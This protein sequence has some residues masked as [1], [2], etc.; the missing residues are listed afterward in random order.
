MVMDTPVLST[1]AP[2]AGTLGATPAI[3]MSR[4]AWGS[5]F[6]GALAAAA[7]GA[8]LLTFGLGI[9]L[10]LASP[11]AT[12]Q[13]TSSSLAF[14]SGLWL[15]LTALAS[16]ALGGYIVGR[17]RLP[18]APPG[19]EEAEFG[20]GVHGLT[21][22][23]MVVVLAATF[24]L[25]M[26]ALAKPNIGDMAEPNA[27]TAEALLAFELDHLF[28][29]DRAPAANEGETRAQAARI[30]SSGLGHSGI[31]PDDRSYLVRMTAGRTGLTP[32]EAEGRVTQVLR[33]ADTAVSNARHSGVILTF[34]TV[35]SL[36]L[37]AA[38]A[39]YTALLGGE[40]RDQNLVP[41]FWIRHRPPGSRRMSSPPL[42]G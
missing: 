30:I 23:A 12:W 18:I 41:T 24:A 19:S 1:R 13:D 31:S 17:T 6:A 8:I 38:T 3:V 2:E 28:R 14:A 7:L 20:D 26:A 36:L 29:S 21:A 34:M 9:G 11:A 42:G 22:W 5:I 16:L 32:T 4:L 40:H 35:V 33:E 25:A 37:G 10:S 15:I 39:W 27:S